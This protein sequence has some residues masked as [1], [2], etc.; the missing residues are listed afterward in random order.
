MAEIQALLQGYREFYNVYFASGDHL[1]K[2]LTKVGQSPKT[3]IIAC[4]DSRVDPSIITNSEPGDIFVIRNVANLVPPY[5]I[6]ESGRHGVSA[7]LEFAVCIL[8]VKHIVILGHS[9]C[10]GIHAL[11]H[12]DRMADTDFIGSWMDIAKPAKEKT[13]KHAENMNEVTLQHHCE[14]ESILL[15]LDNLLTFP[16]IKSRISSGA[17]KL[18]GW[19]FSLEEGHLHEYNPQRAVFEQISIT[20]EIE[21]FSA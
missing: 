7:A 5:E 12:S 18:H 21:S 11:L 9:G 4:S 1:Y 15:S 2:E 10:A 17:L 13:I 14:Q 19:Y 3:L 20:P 16:W 6:Q 8:E